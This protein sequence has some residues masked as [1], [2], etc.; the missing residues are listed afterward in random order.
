MNDCESLSGFI[1]CTNQQSDHFPGLLRSSV[2]RGMYQYRRGHGFNSRIGLH[3][4][5]A[6]FSLQ[7]KW[8][9]LLR[10]SLSY[11]NNCISDTYM[12]QI[13]PKIVRNDF[14]QFGLL[15]FVPK[16]LEDFFLG[17]ISGKKAFELLKLQILKIYPMQNSIFLKRIEFS[18][19]IVIF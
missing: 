8:C 6:L 1:T 18:F 16:I 15:C 19:L 11:S 12:L 10:R 3:V 4:F 2:G 14:N 9:S 5:K 13:Q 7:V 17:F